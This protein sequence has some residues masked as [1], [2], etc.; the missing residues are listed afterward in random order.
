[1]EF[2]TGVNLLRCLSSPLAE[3]LDLG[4][5]RRLS[6]QPLVT[7]A[8]GRSDTLFWPPQDPH[9]CGIFTQT[10]KILKRKVTPRIS[11]AVGVQHSV[12]GSEQ[13]HTAVVL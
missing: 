7:P 13:L 4:V 11:A 3:S 1:M 12:Q 5:E 2:L 8:P 6:G 10:R 9:T